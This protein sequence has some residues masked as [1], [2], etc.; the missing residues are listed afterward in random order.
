MS[1]LT[2]VVQKLTE[3]NKRLET[4]ERQNAESGTPI[5]RLK[6]A[7]P[8]ILA[9]RAEGE[10]QRK[11]DKEIAAESDAAEAARD[12]VAGTQFS[13]AQDAR[14]PVPG[15]IEETSAKSDLIAAKQGDL[16]AENT[17]LQNM[18]LEAIRDPN[19]EGIKIQIQM[20]KEALGRVEDT[21]TDL[22][23]AMREDAENQLDAMPSLAVQ[24]EMAN[25]ESERRKEELASAFSPLKDGLGK[26]GTFFS[27]LKDRATGG[28][29]TFLKAF[30]LAAGLGA[31]IA[32]L[33]S[34]FLK[35]L[36]SEENLKKIADGIKNM[37]NFFD[38][39]V[40]YFTGSGA[41]LTPSLLDATAIGAAIVGIGAGIKL[42][43]GFLFPTDKE[44]KDA[45]RGAKLGGLLKFTLVATAI[46]ALAS[47]IS[48]GFERYKETGEL[49]KAIIAG[50]AGTLNFLTFG[51]FGQ[52][53]I[54]AGLT[55]AYEAFVRDI[56]NPIYKFLE[57]AGFT[58]FGKFSDAQLRVNKARNTL[59]GAEKDLL[60]EQQKLVNL[61]AEE[62]MLLEKSERGELTTTEQR[63]LEKGIPYYIKQATLRLENIEKRVARDAAALA[64]LETPEF[65]AAEKRRLQ[66]EQ[67]KEEALTK[68]LQTSS[69]AVAL[70]AEAAGDTRAGFLRT[71]DLANMPTGMM[72]GNVNVV[73]NRGG[74]TTTINKTISDVFVSNPLIAEKM[75]GSQ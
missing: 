45:T 56:F 32:F 7:L 61:K 37:G 55:K 54:E 52:E 29:L 53:K 70:A 36:L 17:K 66:D 42:L 68:K 26:I 16:I 23:Q 40:S 1:D 46:G 18:Q 74:D 33:E 57:D 21:I 24:E 12:K 22:E 10:K 8:E 69:T 30:G 4:L 48:E 28:A 75:L 65:L 13:E 11:Q 73:N 3:T 27:G 43:K 35:N 38:E 58:G 64:K 5:E 44:L 60:A 49:D 6:D 9:E 71:N 72:G 25:E 2:K 51:L 62:A 34:D 31:L 15:I 50:F 19:N 41:L 47:G 39:V 20:Q 67:R 59:A 63:R 14:V